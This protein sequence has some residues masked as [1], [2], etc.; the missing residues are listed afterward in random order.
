VLLESTATPVGM[1]Y[2]VEPWLADGVK[3]TCGAMLYVPAA[4]T[5]INPEGRPPPTMVFQVEPPAVGVRVTVLKPF[6]IPPKP[7]VMIDPTGHPVV[8]ATR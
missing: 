7:F 8:F 4:V 2:G 6:A 3:M 1:M 5:E